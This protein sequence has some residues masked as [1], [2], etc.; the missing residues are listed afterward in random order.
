MDFKERWVV[1]AASVL[2]VSASMGY[3]AEEGEAAMGKKTYLIR[4]E[5]HKQF[6]VDSEV[7]VVAR[8]QID[9]ALYVDVAGLRVFVPD[10]KS[11]RM[12]R[13]HL[14][15]QWAAR[16][17]VTDI[18]CNHQSETG[19]E[20]DLIPVRS[21][22]G[23]RLGT[24]GMVLLEGGEYLRPGEYFI[25]NYVTVP[26]KVKGGRYRVLLS[27]F[28]MDKYPVTNTQYCQFLNDGNSGYHTPWSR[29]I[30][31]N[32]HGKFVPA[33]GILGALPVVAVN[34]YQ[35]VGYARWAGKRLPTEAEWEYAAGGKE[36]RKYPWGNEEPDNTRVNA[37]F[38]GG[39]YV[40]PVHAFP[41]GA[42][43]EGIC[44]IGGNSAD[45]VADYY[46]EDYY[47]KA[48]RGGV[49]EDPQGPKT[50]SPAHKY[51][52]MFKGYCIAAKDAGM[53]RV[54]KRHSRPPLLPSCIGF[55][56]VKS[57]VR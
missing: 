9:A 3:A 36:G 51:R 55:R 53:L 54:L 34:W 27:S 8:D 44:D 49:L 23:K 16:R 4:P 29:V 15:G 17:F 21:R 28:Y 2:T 12:L 45:W 11:Q 33:A 52:R 40:M 50:G 19:I 35:A 43:P 39:K 42:T 5:H 38:L 57:A 6:G 31:K 56:C 22:Q 25:S 37:M 30:V 46:D 48:P 10:R 32:R 18:L 47:R 1:I 41:A 26:R 7:E 20:P 24:E 13:G 14:A